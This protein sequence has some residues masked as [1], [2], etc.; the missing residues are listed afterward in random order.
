V[1]MTSPFNNVVGEGRGIRGDWAVG[2][3]HATGRGWG[4]RG[5]L[6]LRSGD[7]GRP[8]PAQSPLAR[9]AVCGRARLQVLTS[10]PRLQFLV[11]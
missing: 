9:A 7:A 11:C 3:G 2:G 10:G 5:G 6:T 8:A 1:A 4:R